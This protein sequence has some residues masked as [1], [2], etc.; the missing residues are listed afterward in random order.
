[1]ERRRRWRRSDGVKERDNE[2][3]EV[4]ERRVRDHKRRGEWKVV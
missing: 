2:V 3:E 4:E 1:V